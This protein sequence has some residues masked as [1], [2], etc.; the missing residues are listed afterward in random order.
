MKYFYK[1]ERENGCTVYY[2]SRGRF[3]S[4]FAFLRYLIDGINKYSVCEVIGVKAVKR[5]PT[6]DY[7]EID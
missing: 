4:V 6:Q 7:F 3:A 2:A 1:V 5:L